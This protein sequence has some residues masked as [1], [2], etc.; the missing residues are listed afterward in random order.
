M[1]VLLITQ[2]VYSKIVG[3]LPELMKPT[4]IAV[5]DNRLYV[6]QD[7]TVFIYDLKTL[8]LIKKFG[9]QGEGPEEFPVI[10]GIPL[11]VLVRENHIQVDSPN[12]ITLFTKDGE[13]IKMIKTKGGTFTLAHQPVGDDHY[14]AISFYREDEFNYF[15]V[16]LYDAEMKKVKTLLKMKRG[17]QDQGKIPI[18]QDQA[19]VATYKDKIYLASEQGFTVY[20]INIKGDVVHTYKMKDYKRVKFEDKH[21]DLIIEAMEKNPLQRGAVELIKQRG[22]FPD[23]FPAILNLFVVDDLINI[24]TWE[25]KGEKFKFYLF[26]TDWKLKDEVY[27]GFRMQGVLNPYPATFRNGNLYQ[28]VENDDEQWELFVN[29][30][31]SE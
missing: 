9:R 28:V 21:R 5:G 24:V 3:V 25:R 26:D 13:F 15:S 10:A 30:I 14:V 29:P 4:S 12:R 2:C 16:N 8:K 11:A 17:Y 20:T 22:Q 7:A 27:V 6:A 31:K 18:F 1:L 19:Q 23:Y